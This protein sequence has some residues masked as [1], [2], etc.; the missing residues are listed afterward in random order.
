ME[1]AEGEIVEGLEFVGVGL[2]AV[3]GEVLRGAQNKDAPLGFELVD[4]VQTL[5][6]IGI[7]DTESL[8]QFGVAGVEDL[9]EQFEVVVGIDALWASEDN[10][11]PVAAFLKAFIQGD[12]VDNTA[13]EVLFAPVEDR[14]A[15]KRQ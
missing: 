12:I 9:T 14:F 7:A 13:I 10:N 6:V 11:N 1:V 4:P 8:L 15:Q 2:E 3:D 5:A